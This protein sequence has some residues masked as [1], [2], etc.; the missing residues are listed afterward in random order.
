MGPTPSDL[1]VISLR[2]RELGQV[3]N[4]LDPAPFHEKDLDP[5]AREYILG[6]ARDEPGDAKLILWVEIE[7][8][9]PVADSA[10]ILREAIHNDFA[11]QADLR[12]RDLREL[13]R[14]GRTAL[15]IG[16]VF[17][18]GCLFLAQVLEP[19]TR[20]FIRILRESLLIGGWVAMW[21]PLEIFL[22]D[23]WPITRRIRL[24]DRMARCEVRVHALSSRTPGP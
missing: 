17:L 22:Y 14:Y 6:R 24:L 3:F 4:S 18:A 15:A 21:R 9:P 1:G 23:W 13:L 11:A 5:V 19:H 7:R 8:P 10:A 2:L 16:I 20:G 12:R